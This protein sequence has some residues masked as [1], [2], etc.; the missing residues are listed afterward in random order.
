LREERRG[1]VQDAQEGAILLQVHADERGDRGEEREPVK[2]RPRPPRRGRRRRERR[3]AEV[4]PGDSER[5]EQREKA[6]VEGNEIGVE[7]ERASSLRDTVGPAPRMRRRVRVVGSDRLCRPPGIPAGPG[8]RLLWSSTWRRRIGSW[9]KAVATSSR[10]TTEMLQSLNRSPGIS[11]T[12]AIPA[13]TRAS[14]A[15]SSS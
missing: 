9:A 10:R 7:G 2:P 15:W 8:P 5:G 12:P 1:A 14:S 6:G 3:R 4:G 11:A 13:R